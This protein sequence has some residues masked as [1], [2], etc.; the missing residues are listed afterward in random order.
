MDDVSIVDP[1]RLS[2]SNP[3]HDGD[4]LTPVVELDSIGV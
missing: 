1:V 3:L 2:P 4:A